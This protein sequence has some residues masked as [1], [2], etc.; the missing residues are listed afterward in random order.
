MSIFSMFSGS[1]VSQREKELES[2]MSALD[3]SMARIEFSMDGTILDANQN[4]L[5]VMGYSLDEV[6]GKHHRIFVD[7]EYRESEEYSDFWHILNR[8]KFHQAEYLRIA[9]G[10]KE[11]WIQ[12]SY[13]PV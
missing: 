12:A 2:V 13:N 10:G 4:F 1:G 5:D 11:V 6:K 8:G 7:S 3:L 9:K